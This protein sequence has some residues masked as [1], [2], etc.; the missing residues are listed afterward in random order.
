MYLS[1]I[2]PSPSLFDNGKWRKFEIKNRCIRSHVPW[3]HELKIGMQT[4]AK[5]NN[6]SIF[7][8]ILLYFLIQ[9][10]LDMTVFQIQINLKLLTNLNWKKKCFERNIID[11]E[12]YQNQFS[13]PRI[14]CSNTKRSLFLYLCIMTLTSFLYC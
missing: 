9:N 5:Y 12:K 14:S 10:I 3:I 7:Y 8:K 6:W 4:Y 13:L 1:L 2:N 11:L